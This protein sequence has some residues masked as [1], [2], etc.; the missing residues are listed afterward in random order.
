MECPLEN[1]NYGNSTQDLGNG[2]SEEHQGTILASMDTIKIGIYFF[3]WIFGLA[4]NF[5]VLLS[6]YYSRGR[7]VAV[8]LVANLALAD[9]LFSCTMPLWIFETLHNRTWL[10]GD[11]FCKLVTFLTIINFY[12]SVIFLLAISIDRLLAICYPLK[13][14]QYRNSRNAVVISII[15]W[16]TVSCISSISLK[17]RYIE[18]ASVPNCNSTNS[19]TESHEKA[20]CKSVMNLTDGE[21]CYCIWD[22]K[23]EPIYR[24]VQLVFAHSSM[25]VICGNYVRILHALYNS[26][27]YRE[28][29]NSRRFRVTASRGAKSSNI[30]SN[31]MHQNSQRQ[32]HRTSRRVT[33]QMTA[34]TFTFFACWLPRN[35]LYTMMV[36][37]PR[38]EQ[39]GTVFYHCVTL[40]SIISFSNSALAPILYLAFSNK[41][42]E[43]LCDLFCASSFLKNLISRIRNQFNQQPEVLQEP[44]GVA[45]SSTEDEL[46]SNQM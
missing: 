14:M 39:L 45:L 7:T 5:L 26:P 8:I 37:L 32:R 44:T 15:I 16:L 28:N 27:L 33:L 18:P 36:M 25:F 42:R 12:C 13:M 43:I 3:T 4:A 2:T 10:F 23:F 1:D 40:S 30:L 29:S 22:G 11:L 41:S 19:T 34:M 31:E 46:L 17:F 38:T 24:T 9:F 35:I 6:V 21:D 20:S